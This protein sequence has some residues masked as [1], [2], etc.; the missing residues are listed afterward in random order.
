MR[1]LLCRQCNVAIGLL[2]DRHS[3]IHN[4]AQYL[5]VHQNVY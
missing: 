4:A 2:Q 3:V 5:E 1:G